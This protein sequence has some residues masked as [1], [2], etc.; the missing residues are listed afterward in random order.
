MRITQS[1]LQN[2]ML[3]NLYSSQAQMNKYL[4]QINTGKKIS[5]PSDDPV[6]VMKGMGYRTEVTEVEQY[7][8]NTSEIWNWMDH[9]DDALDKATKAMQRIE[10]LAVQAA[11]DTYDKDEREAIAKEV[12]QLQRQL[13]EIANTNVNGKYIFNGTDTNLQPVEVDAEG[14]VIVT[15]TD[16]RNQYVNI[17]VSKGI[18]FDV[19]M[20]P[21]KM[22][23]KELFANI[24]DFISALKSDDSN[25]QDEMNSALENLRKGTT[26]IVNTRAEL[27][28]KMNRLEL[29]ED[30]LSHQEII[31]KDTMMKNEG[32]DFEEAVMNLLTQEVIHRAALS[33]GSKIIQPSL[34][35]FLR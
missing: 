12:E 10:E 23:N 15:D 3:K 18:T 13:V 27:G 34:V 32:V 30:R 4:T 1:M 6:I 17:E 8:R 29:I 21:D 20:D 14:N 22:F 16:G 28:A 2:N 11:N 33:A 26:D 24:D 35:D 31:A 5:R 7:R 25:Q 19:N 9:T